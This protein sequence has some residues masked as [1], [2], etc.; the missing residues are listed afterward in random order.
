[1]E[2]SVK[3]YSNLNLQGVILEKYKCLV[4]DIYIQVKIY[5]EHFQD[6][7]FEVEIKMSQEKQSYEIKSKEANGKEV[8][9]SKMVKESADVPKMTSNNVSSSMILNSITPGISNDSTENIIKEDSPNSSKQDGSD[10]SDLSKKNELT[11][12][13]NV[14]ERKS[15]SDVS[16]TDN[17]NLIANQNIIE[18]SSE[19]QGSNLTIMVLK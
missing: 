11:T 18:F 19:G 9:N 8:V 12:N 15:S 5:L 7:I 14:E 17:P 3:D 16:A 10:T 13:T 4:C 2:K 1:M 6:H